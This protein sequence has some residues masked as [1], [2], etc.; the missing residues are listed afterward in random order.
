VAHWGLVSEESFREMNPGISWTTLSDAERM[1]WEMMDNAAFLFLI[2]GIA[3]VLG[4][5]GL[6]VGSMLRKPKKS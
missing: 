3:L 2:V 4:F 6:Y 1:S 5:I